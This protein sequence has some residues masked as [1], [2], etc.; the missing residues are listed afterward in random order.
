MA[1]DTTSYLGLKKPDYSETADIA[2]INDNMD[3]IDGAMQ[4]IDNG[5]G[6]VVDGAK[7]TFT[8]GAAIGQY[9]IL[10]NSAIVDSGT[11]MI[12]DG[13]YTAAK[14]IP[15]NTTIDKSYLTAVSGGGLNS[16]SDQ[17][18]TLSSKLTMDLLW[19]NPSPTSTFAAQT[20]AI[21]LSEYTAVA[22][23]LKGYYTDT[24]GDGETGRYGVNT[25]IIPLGVWGC[26]FSPFRG[27]AYRSANPTS[28]G[29]EF[30]TGYI[31][32]VSG[33]TPNPCVPLLIYGI[34]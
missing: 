23:Y 15:Y 1:I 17:I 28:T 26:L 11:T 6:I 8:S 3:T 29:V 12:P 2:D 24:A 18:K 33:D 25:V 16:L 9:V 4:G 7:T 20:V 27:G 14:V 13:L 32:G 34:R 31:S 22:I 5:I 21:D 30:S 19:T 10:K